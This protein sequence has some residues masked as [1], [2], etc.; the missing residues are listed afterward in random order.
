MPRTTAGK[1][2]R[3]AEEAP[4]TVPRLSESKLKDLTWSLDI[5]DRENKV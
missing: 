3:A 2:I 5:Y 1:D 4:I